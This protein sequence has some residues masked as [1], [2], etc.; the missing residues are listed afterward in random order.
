MDW[1]QIFALTVNGL[2]EKLTGMGFSTNAHKPTLEDRLCDNDG[3]D[4]DVDLFQSS[5]MQSWEVRRPA[6][7]LHIIEGSLASFSDIGNPTVEEWLVDYEDKSTAV[8]RDD[9]HF[10]FQV[11]LD[12]GCELCLM[13]YDVLMMLGEVEMEAVER[14]KRQ[15]SKQD[16]QFQS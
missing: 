7:T 10:K 5:V 3:S 8:Q 2:I 11:L 1:E 16:W 15:Y 9:F 4:S 14:H 13:R 12:A 6:L